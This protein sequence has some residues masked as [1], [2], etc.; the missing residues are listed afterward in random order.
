M[1]KITAETRQEFKIKTEPY[2]NAIDATLKKEKDMVALMAHDK[3]GLAYKKLLLCEDMIYI[4]TLYVA[5]NTISETMLETKNQDALNEARKVLYKAIIYLEDI[6]TNVIDCPYSNLEPK[7]AEISNTP[8]E[9]RYYLLRK[10]GMAIKMVIDGFGE[11]SKWKWSFVE[12]QGRYATVFK[13]MLNMKEVA[14][15]YFDPRDSQ[16]EIVLLFVRMI[17]KLLDQSAMGYRDRYELST[18]RVDDMRMAINYLLALRRIAIVL[19][20]K[21]AAEEIKKKAIAWNDKMDAD[22]KAGKA[23]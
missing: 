19:N 1:A 12:L 17:R 18:H 5:I 16:Y 22:Q 13:N 11:N 23:S 7:I 2:K 21:D 20:D 14:K 4:S 3:S 15:V 6:V 10:I 8:L 9:K